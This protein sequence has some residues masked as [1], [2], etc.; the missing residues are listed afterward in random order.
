MNFKHVID[1]AELA[2]MKS[3]FSNT[4]VSGDENKILKWL[5][6]QVNKISVKVERIDLDNISKWKFDKKEGVICHETGQ[7]FSIQGIEVTTNWGGVNKWDQPIINQPEIGYLGFIVKEFNGVLHFLM[8]AKIEPGNINHVQ[9]SPTIQATKSNYSQVHQGAKTPYLDYFKNIDNENVL[10]DQLQSE[11]G[12]RFLRKRNR[13]IVIFVKENIELLDNFIWLTLGQIK[14][15]MKLDN[16]VNMDTRTVISCINYGSYDLNSI[17]MFDHISN[18][19]VS[20]KNLNFEFMKSALINDIYENEINDVIHKI[21]KIKSKF[22]LIIKDKSLRQLNDWIISK[23]EISREDGKYF[24]VIAVNVSISNREVKAWQQPM[25]QPSQ[26]GLCA[27]V[28][29]KIKGIMHFLVQLKVE[30]G[31]RDIV[32]LAPTIQC[33]TGDY[34][35]HDS[36]PVD[37]LDLVLNAEKKNIF[38]HLKNLP[39]Q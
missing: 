6:E 17:I 30:C 2:F 8:Q 12:S 1:K 20:K 38:N 10:L 3:I 5:S 21:T 4:G 15:L 33:I 28:C 39:K 29:K 22:D 32:E 36:Q 34:T 14:N 18:L 16:V 31:N 27:F 11:Q 35:L 25:I 7:F 37:F 23:D 26:T 9:L 13:N 24:K 19:N